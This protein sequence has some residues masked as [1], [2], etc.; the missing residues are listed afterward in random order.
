VSSVSLTVEGGV[1][2]LALDAPILS[3]EALRRLATTL[4][5]L[6][7]RRTPTPLVLASNHSTIFLAGAHLAEIAELDADSCVEYANLGRSV[8]DALEHHPAPVVAAVDGSCSGGGFDLVLA[9]DAVVAS[10]RA[11][12]SHPGVFRGLVTGWSGTSRLPAS[13]GASMA[14]RLLLEG[15]ATDAAGLLEAGVVVEVSSDPRR[16]AVA[17]ADRLDHLPRSRVRLWRALRGS[18]FIDRFRAL[19][20]E[21]S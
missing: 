1:T 15:S 13:V 9:C 19:M 16:T 14:K 4:D 18:P 10:D 8:A 2:I 12:F 7:G 20:V 17:V 6:E 11:T 3:R 5:D 21:K